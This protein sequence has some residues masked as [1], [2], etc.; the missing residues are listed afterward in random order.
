[1]PCNGYVCHAHLAGQ[2]QS[3]PTTCFQHE[4]EY[5]CCVFG[6]LLSMQPNS[7]SQ[8]A[9]TSSLANQYVLCCAYSSNIDAMQNQ[10][11][12]LM[13][14]WLACRAEKQQQ[15][16]EPALRLASRSFPAR[17]QPARLTPGLLLQ[18]GPI[19]RRKGCLAGALGTQRRS[20]SS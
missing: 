6:L 12:C 5:R 13:L 9:K 4:S 20:A 18:V 19:I 10:M 17:N 11:L 7:Q 8:S 2:W 14:L 3:H 16:V 15:K 1:M